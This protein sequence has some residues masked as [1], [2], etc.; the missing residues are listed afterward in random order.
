M[1]TNVK[2]VGR[3]GKRNDS[4][5]QAS[6]RSENYELKDTF[7]TTCQSLAQITAWMLTMFFLK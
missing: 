3:A 5:L 6:I 4:V 1:M 2:K 7:K